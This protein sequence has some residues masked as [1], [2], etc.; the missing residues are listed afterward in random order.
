M[1]FND[2]ENA[3]SNSHSSDME[4]GPAFS[5]SSYNKD[6]DSPPSIK[7]KLTFSGDNNRDFELIEREIGMCRPVCS[8]SLIKTKRFLFFSFCC[9]LKMVYAK[10]MS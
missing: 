8:S 7:R 4:F 6:D 9:S 5:S 1:K 10:F 3:I 2:N